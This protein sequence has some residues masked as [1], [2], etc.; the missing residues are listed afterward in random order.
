MMT[1]LQVTSD[2]TLIVVKA[3]EKPK[4]I[5]N[6]MIQSKLNTKKISVDAS[7]CSYEDYQIL[8][9]LLQLRFE[10]HFETG[11]IKIYR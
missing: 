3:T 7:N 5:V 11:R 8:V 9:Q 4:D 6:R 10:H 1:T 2:C